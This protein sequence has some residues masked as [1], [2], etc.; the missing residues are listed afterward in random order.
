MKTLTPTELEKLPKCTYDTFGKCHI[1]I[2]KRVVKECVM[3]RLD[4][5]LGDLEYNHSASAVHGLDILKIILEELDVIP[6]EAKF[7]KRK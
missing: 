6:E 5:I 3:C 1:E 7:Y 2:E 4:G